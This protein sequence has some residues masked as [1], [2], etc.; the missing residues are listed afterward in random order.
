MWMVSAFAIYSLRWG[1]MYL[2]RM[3]NHWI[4]TCPVVAF[5]PPGDCPRAE[6]ASFAWRTPAAAAVFQGWCAVTS[7][8]LCPHWAVGRRWQGWPDVG[9]FHSDRDGVLLSDTG[10][11]WFANRGQIAEV[12][13]VARLSRD[14][15]RVC[16]LAARTVEGCEKINLE[17]LIFKDNGKSVPSRWGQCNPAGWIL[18]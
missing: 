15:C 14:E 12:W 7:R 13:A 3:A 11:G 16:A 9:R 6:H 2:D 1:C 10:R 5:H 8:N 17:I 4:R 18:G